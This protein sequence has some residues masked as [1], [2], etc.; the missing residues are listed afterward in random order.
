[1]S[2]DKKVCNK[3]VKFQETALIKP[4]YFI[5]SNG[6]PN[7][8]NSDN[9]IKFVLSRRTPNESSNK[10]QLRHLVVIDKNIKESAVKKTVKHKFVEENFKIPVVKE[11]P[12]KDNNK[13]NL[14]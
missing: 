11:P 6:L 5:A 8:L 1:M 14:Y 10:T 7:I 4:D 9:P 12:K 3:S 2:K 13:K